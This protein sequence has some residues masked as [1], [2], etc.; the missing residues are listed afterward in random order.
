MQSGE[1]KITGKGHKRALML[2]HEISSDETGAHTELNVNINV[3][4]QQQKT[5]L[6][7]HKW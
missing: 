2:T 4:D 1:S 5:K 7:L 6:S 3:W